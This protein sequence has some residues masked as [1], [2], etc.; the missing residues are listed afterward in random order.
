MLESLEVEK[1]HDERIQSDRVEK[2]IGESNGLVC[3]DRKVSGVPMVSGLHNYHVP[4]DGVRA[5][6]QEVLSEAV[7]MA[8]G[9]TQFST[10]YRPDD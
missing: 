9:T 1:I 6:E 4:R 8:H 5:G 10:S 2:R 3:H 7:I